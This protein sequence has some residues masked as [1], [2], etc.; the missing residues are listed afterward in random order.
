MLTR[1]IIDLYAWLVE[2]LLWGGVL[3]AAFVGYSHFDQLMIVFGVIIEPTVPN[4]LVG[5]IICAAIALI[6]SAIILA[7]FLV[8]FDIRQSARSIES[9]MGRGA[10]LDLTNNRSDPRV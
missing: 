8:L 9:K 10:A 5:S 3:L 1:I 2:C 6:F 4:K 7:P